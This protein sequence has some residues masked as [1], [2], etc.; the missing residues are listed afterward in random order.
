MGW[1][2]VKGLAIHHSASANHVK[3]DHEDCKTVWAGIKKYHLSKGYRDIAYNYGVCAHGRVLTGR[4][5][6]DNSGA[7]GDTT[8]NAQYGAICV[9]GLSPKATEVVSN[10]IKRLRGTWLERFPTARLVVPHSALNQTACPGDPLRAYIKN[11][12]YE[13]EDLPQFTEAQAQWLKDF[14]KSQKEVGAKPTSLAR[15]VQWYR[16]CK[17]WWVKPTG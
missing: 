3:V 2:N 9:L 12:K 17:A 14:V 6:A 5:W 1:S 13:E 8:V 16:Y 7:N 4:T 15:V 10:G 11:K